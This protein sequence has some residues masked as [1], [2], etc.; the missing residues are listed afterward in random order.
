[1]GLI[2]LMFTVALWQCSE[3]KDW[4]D[5][6]DSDP[7]G[8]VRD[9]QVIN[10]NGGAFIKY[11]LPGDKD[12]R[13]VKAIY[14]FNN[15]ESR[16][17]FASAFVDSIVLEGYTDTNEHIVE[18]YAIDESGNLSEAVPV[19]IQPLTPPIELIRKSLQVTATFGG[20]YAK[21]D[22][23]FNKAM[24]I[25]LFTIDSVGDRVLYDR[26][27]S[28]SAKG[29][30]TFRGFENKEQA[31]YFE[32]RDR[33]N[34][35]SLPL[36]TLMTPVFETQI[37]GRTE[38]GNDIWFLYGDAD[39]TNKLRGEV[40]GPFV[41]GT[42]GVFRNIH[43]GIQ[44]V[45]LNG[46]WFVDIYTMS[47]FVSGGSTSSLYPQYF[48]I[49]MGRK[50]TYSRLKYFARNRTPI[51]SAWVW[52]D[53]EVW[54]TNEPEPVGEIKNDEDL[55]KSLQYWTCW[56]EIGGTDSWKNGGRWKKLCDCIITFPSGTLNTVTSVTSAEDVAF[57]RAGFEYSVD[58]D[59]TTE[60]FRYLRFVMKKQ[61]VSP[62]YIQIGELEFYGA[63]AD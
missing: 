3:V 46:L 53:F 33:W 22:N 32:L 36:D 31:F 60:P 7:P 40:Y 5:A 17:V 28:N 44:L 61:N 4:S 39:G 38:L 59:M 12:L 62:T 50:A 9:V 1:M 2:C 34:N 35:Y 30:Y 24:D 49:D 57:F 51:Y 20:V 8:P 23:P 42:N 29:G 10:L 47:K 26:Y 13:G 48:T 63:Y 15:N 43:D 25:T 37:K 45:D 52:Y 18:L 19:T 11:V 14:S 6:K 21:W 55:L 16:E 54:G 58:P 56:E 27:Y 41:N